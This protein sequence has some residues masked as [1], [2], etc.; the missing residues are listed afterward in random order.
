MTTYNHPFSKDD[1]EAISANIPVFGEV[2]GARVVYAYEADAKTA[3]EVRVKDA[4]A[5]GMAKN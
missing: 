3:S 4:G 2:K 5:K 1:H